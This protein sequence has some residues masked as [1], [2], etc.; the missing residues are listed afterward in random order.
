MVL[1]E[2]GRGGMGIVYRCKDRKLLKDVAVKVIGWTFED[3]AVIRFHKEAKTLAQLKHPNILGVQHFG[4]SD[5]DSFFLVMDLLTGRSLS[6]LIELEKLPSFEEALEIFIQLCDG[7]AHAHNKGILHRDIKPSNV[8]VARYEA[9]ELQVVIT[10]FG[11]AKLVVEDQSLT[12]TG[13]SM[14][15]PPYM[16]PEQCDGKPIDERSDIYSLGCLM[17]EL[18]TTTR[19]FLGETVPHLLMQHIREQPPTLAERAPDRNYPPEMDRIIAKCLAKDPSDRYAKA[20]LLRADLQQLKD[21]I[22][23]VSFAQHSEESGAYSPS[24]SF[25]RTGAYIISGMQNALRPSQ[26]KKFIAGAIAVLVLFGGG[27]GYFFWQLNLQHGKDQK[28]DDAIKSYQFEALKDQTGLALNPEPSNKEPKRL[29]EQKMWVKIERDAKAAL[30]EVTTAS[31]KQLGFIQGGAN[32][33]W[34][35]LSGSDVKDEDFNAVTSL[36]IRGFLLNKTQITDRALEVLSKIDTLEELYMDDTKITDQGL[37]YLIKNG[38]EWLNLITVHRTNVT[39]EGIKYISQYAKLAWLG[40]D[41]CKN[42]TGSN[43]DLLHDNS[44]LFHLGLRGTGFQVANIPKLGKLRKLP[45]L[46]L[47]NLNLTD[48]DVK[49]LVDTHIP[50]LEILNLNDNK[51][52][53]EEGLLELTKVKTLQSVHIKGCPKLTKPVVDNFQTACGDKPVIVYRE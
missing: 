53:S 22:C 21:S 42:I 31:H 3:D 38:Q 34:L 30:Q 46:D 20:K 7:L 14:G 18:L 52:L 33:D 28:L 4:H 49:A 25:L 12:Q 37:K 16:S 51:E 40:L 23:N 8:F 5:D 19:P 41:D 29:R 10:D 45:S 13:I 9:G 44:D 1:E 24:K 17:F 6:E 35:D 2:L 47:S 26:E 36:K 15:S 48:A 32:P 50:E 27:V 39:D 11:L 43:I